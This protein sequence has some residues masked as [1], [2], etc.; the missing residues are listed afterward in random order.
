MF[1]NNIIYFMVFSFLSK[2]TYN[3]SYTHSHTDGR[4]N[5]A[6]GQPARQ[7]QLGLGVRDTLTLQ[8]EPGVELEMVA[9]PPTL[10]PELSRPPITNPGLPVKSRHSSNRKRRPSGMEMG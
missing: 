7:G 10:P 4:A 5:H 1:P 8:E 2:A 6:G 3:G 9:G